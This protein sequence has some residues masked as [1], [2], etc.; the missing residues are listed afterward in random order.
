MN[1][2]NNHRTEKK[3][4]TKKESTSSVKKNKIK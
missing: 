3:A 2:N 1:I 4:K